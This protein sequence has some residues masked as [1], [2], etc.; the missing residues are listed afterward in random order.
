MGRCPH[1]NTDV[2][3][4]ACPTF[5]EACT[6][7]KEINKDTVWLVVMNELTV[8]HKDCYLQVR[9]KAFLCSIEKFV[10]SFPF[11]HVCVGN[12]LLVPGLPGWFVC[13]CGCL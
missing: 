3:C 6:K 10:V 8:G 2:T 4:T 1:H 7:N 5:A 13:S 12:S 9:A 11:Y